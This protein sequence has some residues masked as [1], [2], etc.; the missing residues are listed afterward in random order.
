MTAVVHHEGHP[1][2]LLTA[3]EGHEAGGSAGCRRGT[4]DGNGGEDRRPTI[5]GAVPVTAEYWTIENHRR[6][7]P[8]Y[9]RIREALILKIMGPIASAPA[10]QEE[11]ELKV[12]EALLCQGFAGRLANQVRVDGGITKRNSHSKQRTLVLAVPHP[13]FQMELRPHLAGLQKVIEGLGFQKLTIR[14]G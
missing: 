14:I 2:T 12:R 4:K 3:G 7:L 13:A 6:K 5:A 11:V 1:S 8:D 10:A 9:D